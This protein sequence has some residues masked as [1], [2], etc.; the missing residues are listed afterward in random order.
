MEM[1]TH[2]LGI[3]AITC[4]IIIGACALLMPIFVWLIYRNV[5]V[6]ASLFKK[7]YQN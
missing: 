3:F 6:I 2:L 7:Y 4:L 1:L 5:A